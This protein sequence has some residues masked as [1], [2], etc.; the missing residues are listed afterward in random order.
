[1]E[2]QEQQVEQQVEQPA[3]PELGIADLQNLKTLVEMAIRRGAY[4][5]NEISSV[6]AVYDRVSAFLN[7]VAP[8]PTAESAPEGEQTQEQ[9]AQ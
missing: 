2:N 7:A 1:M 8:A 6:G 4:G 5:P 3:Q 9:A